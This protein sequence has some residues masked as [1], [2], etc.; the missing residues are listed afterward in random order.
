M[1]SAKPS[2]IAGILASLV[3]SLTSGATLAY[4]NEPPINGIADLNQEADYP[5][6]DRILTCF[7]L[8]RIDIGIKQKVDGKIEPMLFT[9]EQLKVFLENEQ[10]KKFLVIVFDRRLIVQSSKQDIE[11]LRK[12][13][14]QFVSPFH[15]ERMVIAADGLEGPCIVEDSQRNVSSN[16]RHF[17]ELVRIPS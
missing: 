1:I 16:L 15:Y 5:A 11:N 14:G 8:D 13:F 9:R 4:A 2:L 10:H 17:F 6:P 12:K 3:A 7:G